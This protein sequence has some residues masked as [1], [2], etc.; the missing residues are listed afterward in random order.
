M[1][2][3]GVNSM[4]ARTIW[5]SAFVSLFGIKHRLVRVVPTICGGFLDVVLFDAAKDLLS[6]A[7][8]AQESE[9]AVDSFCVL[10]G[11]PLASLARQ[12]H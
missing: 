10:A 9:K 2:Q 12:T 5:N 11:T 3:S 1:P 7:T 6:V 8:E 4:A